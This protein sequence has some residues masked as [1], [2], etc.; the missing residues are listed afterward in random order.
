ME[1]EAAKVAER[2]TPQRRSTPASVRPGSGSSLLR[3]LRIPGT[4]SRLPEELERETLEGAAAAVKGEGL[5]TADLAGEGWECLEA[6]DSAGAEWEAAWGWRVGA[7]GGM[8]V[9]RGA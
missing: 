7:A 1:R 6:A 3:E 2:E 8:A 5:E 9:A 4:Q